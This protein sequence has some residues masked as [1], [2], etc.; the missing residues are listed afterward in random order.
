MEEPA[1]SV[2]IWHRIQTPQLLLLL[3]LVVL[4]GCTPPPD[5]PSFDFEDG[6]LQGWTLV[7]GNLPNQ[8]VSSSRKNFHQHGLYFIG[9]ADKPR[10]GYDDARTGIL[11]SPRFV[12]QHDYVLFRIGGGKR[13]AGCY[14]VLKRA[15]DDG[16]IRQAT[17]FNSEYMRTIIWDVSKHRGTE[18][19]FDI[20]DRVTGFW[21]HVNVDQ[22]RFTDG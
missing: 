2:K 11:R 17:G 16:V 4:V 7:R 21:G 15:S 19:Y 20:V 14:L 12:L 3:C 13:P 1:E 10:G 6:T 18:A 8:P 9:T 5:D 22:L